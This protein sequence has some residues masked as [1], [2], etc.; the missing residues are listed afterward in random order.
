M[1][2]QQVI[3]IAKK[4]AAI[5]SNNKMRKQ[6]SG[7]MQKSEENYQKI[8]DALPEYYPTYKMAVQLLEDNRIHL[9]I[10]VAYEY[11]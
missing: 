1:E 8:I 6:F 5:L 3:D 10:G 7:F 2:Q 11:L 9:E 4:T